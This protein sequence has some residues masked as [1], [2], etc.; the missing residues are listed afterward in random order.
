MLLLVATL[1][2]FF[3]PIAAEA[4]AGPTSPVPPCAQADITCF[5]QRTWPVEEWDHVAQVVRCESHGVPSATARNGASVVYGLMQIDAW[6][7]TRWLKDRGFGWE[8]V[9][10]DAYTN[11]LAAH[12]IWTVY[13][14]REWA[15][16]PKAW[17][18]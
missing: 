8:E 2:L 11:L 16:A 14:W 13:G 6:S 3:G 17:Y 9:A 18:R 7:W 5:I 4:P 10:T 1:T 12:E 15:C